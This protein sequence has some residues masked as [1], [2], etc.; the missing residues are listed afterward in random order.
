M[1]S[2]S[3]LDLYRRLPIGL[4]PDKL[5]NVHDL[6]RLIEP[7]LDHARYGAVHLDIDLDAIL[8][9]GEEAHT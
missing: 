3:L 9:D 8:N 6:P 1:R 2:V 7:L 4:D 5:A